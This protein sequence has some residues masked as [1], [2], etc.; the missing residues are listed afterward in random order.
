MGQLD[1]PDCPHSSVFLKTCEILV[2]DEQLARTVQT[3]ILPDGSKDPNELSGAFPLVRLE[4]N[5]SPM[6]WFDPSSQSSW[7]VINVRTCIQSRDA[8][9]R[10]NLWSPISTF[11]FAIG[12]IG[13]ATTS[14]FLGELDEVRLQVGSV[15]FPV[16]SS[17]VKGTTIFNVPVGAYGPGP[18]AVCRG[19][20]Y[21]RNTDGTITLFAGTLNRLW[22]L[23]NST[24]GWVD[25]SKSLLSG[26][27]D[28]PTSYHWQFAQFGSRVIAVQ[29]NSA[30]QTFTLGSSTQFG[31]LGGSPP[32]AAYA[33]VVNRFLVLTGLTS[34]PFRIQWSA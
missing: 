7:L 20:F 32:Q 15:S 29:P 9:D 17:A 26:Y 33:A 31:D 19:F 30:P 6:Q 25:V 8:T 27:T 11:K 1:L 2:E 24:L 3:W 34:T 10:L 22:K 4:P 12:R 13:E 21:A 5:M 16:T 28:L 23:D 18:S 14:T